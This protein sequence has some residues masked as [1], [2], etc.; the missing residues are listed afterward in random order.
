MVGLVGM[1]SGSVWKRE[2]H[3]ALCS[4]KPIAAPLFCWTLGTGTAPTRF[5]GDTVGLGEGIL[6]APSKMHPSRLWI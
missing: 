2:G 3:R 4:Q 6:P 1:Y 5:R